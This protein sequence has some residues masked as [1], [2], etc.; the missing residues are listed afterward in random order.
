MMANS[1]TD[2]AVICDE[3]AHKARV[4]A[5]GNLPRHV[6]IIMDGNGRWASQRGLPRTEGHSASVAVVKDVV[7]AAADLG[8]EVLTLYTFSIENWRRPPGEVFFL[9]SL[10]RDT[11]NDEL[12]ELHAENVRFRTIGRVSRLFPASRAAV[13]NSIE[14][15]KDNTGLVLNLALSYG[16]KLE[17]VDAVRAISR[18][19]E[20]GELASHQINERLIAAHLYTADLP[21]PDLLIRT[22]GEMRI[23]NFMLWQLAYT[24]M[25]VTD[26]LWPD[27]S[28]HD[29]YEAI[30]SYQTRE[31]RFGLTS[32]QLRRGRSQSPAVSVAS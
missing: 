2:P 26:V 25:W 21:D 15:T 16:G 10:L 23:S 18:K 17:I 27:F 31:R 5:R 6:A 29:L 13:R 11:L 12:P 4:L 32:D 8:L 1:P 9:M 30:E 24:E 7:R 3:E 14:T 19:I 22:S 28:R 20:R